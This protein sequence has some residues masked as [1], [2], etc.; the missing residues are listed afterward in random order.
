MPVATINKNRPGI[1]FTNQTASHRAI[2]THPIERNK[3]D[4]IVVSDLAEVFLVMRPTVY[5]ER[6][7]SPKPENPPQSLPLS[8]LPPQSWK[9]C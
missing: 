6:S 2:R 9:P 8:R 3:R 5:Q 4:G 1:H 7:P